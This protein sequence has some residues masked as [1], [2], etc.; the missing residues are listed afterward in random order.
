[1]TLTSLYPLISCSLTYIHT[2]LRLQLEEMLYRVKYPLGFADLNEQGIMEYGTA[3]RY[4]RKVMTSINVEDIDGKLNFNK[5]L[6]ELVNFCMP[7]KKKIPNIEK[8]MKKIKDEQAAALE[9]SEEFSKFGHAYGI[10]H[11]YASITIQNLA[12]QKM[13]RRKVKHMKTMREQG[14]SSEKVR[15]IYLYL[16]GFVLPTSRL[17]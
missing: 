12:R 9:A 15:C 1:M 4:A 5:T 11:V 10:K 7:V 14:N 3:K 6:M 17:Q 8:Q 13:A 16:F 2:I